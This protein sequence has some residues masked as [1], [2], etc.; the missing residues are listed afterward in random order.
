MRSAWL[1]LVVVACGS[2]LSVI[3]LMLTRP[4]AAASAASTETDIEACVLQIGDVTGDG[5]LDFSVSAPGIRNGAVVVYLIAGH[6]EPIPTRL[7][8]SYLRT[9]L[10][11]VL[12]GPAAMPF[13][14]PAEPVALVKRIGGRSK[15]RRRPP[16]AN[17]LIDQ[18]VSYT[19]VDL[20]PLMPGYPL[21]FT[22]IASGINAGGQ[23]VGRF[24]TQQ[25]DR[26]FVYDRG[27]VRDL[28]TLGGHISA[29]RGINRFGQIVG[30]S[31]TG[32]SDNFGFINAAFISDGFLMQ[33]LNLDWSAASA[34]NAAGQIVGEMR[35]TP[36][37]DL[38]H[39][40][41]YEQGA[42]TDLGS[43][44]PLAD[45]AYSS[46]HSINE[47]GQVVGQ[48][49]TYVLGK[50]F[51]LDV[52]LPFARS[53]TSTAP[54]ATSARLASCAVSIPT[55]GSWRR[56]VSRTVWPRTSTTRERLLVLVRRRQRSV[57]MRFCRTDKGSRTL[58][59]SEATGAG[60]M[61]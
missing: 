7:N 57:S 19:M 37:V 33:N 30:Y 46:A 14:C 17:T 56:S 59:R 25:G 29:A 15:V 34:I 4:A 24:F 3:A 40:F 53:C 20:D 47:A 31:L 16:V 60:R 39:A 41:L 58:E 42:A 11:G 32:A 51:P 2:V 55:M 18:P 9:N 61:E 21:G 23:V 6:N 49:N 48:S 38:L 12:R 10:A 35:F 45:S 36:G 27:E 52:I 28:G 13:V 26:A 54:C 50:A 5:L 8:S 44:P 43:L 1:R 22:S